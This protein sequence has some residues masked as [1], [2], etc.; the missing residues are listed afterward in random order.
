MP[1]AMIRRR[2]DHT[3]RGGDY[4]TPEDAVRSAQ[5][6]EI[7]PYD[8]TGPR[9]LDTVGLRLA[10]AGPLLTSPKRLEAIKGEWKDLPKTDSVLAGTERLE[11]PV[12][13]IDALIKATEDEVLKDEFLNIAVEFLRERQTSMG[14]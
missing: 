5:R 13:E 12:E 1:Q 9:R 2:L 10:I 3:A 7:I 8:R 14:G 4:L 6:D 11:D